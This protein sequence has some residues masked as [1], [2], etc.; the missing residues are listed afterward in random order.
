MS[1]NIDSYSIV[2]KSD[3]RDDDASSVISTSSNR[4]TTTFRTRI[5]R[6]EYASAIEESVRAERKGDQLTKLGRHDLAAREYQKVIDIET[7]VLGEH[8]PIVVSFREKIDSD[9]GGWQKSSLTKAMEAL[10]QGLKYEKQGDY[11]RKLGAKEYAKTEYE[12]A[13]K[14]EEVVLGEHHPMAV[15]LKEKI[16]I[17]TK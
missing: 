6:G 13:L 3:V 12:K 15:S 2:P 5:A 9:H 4:Y 10:H 11:L 14:I 1:A 17:S 7:A 8:H 16:I